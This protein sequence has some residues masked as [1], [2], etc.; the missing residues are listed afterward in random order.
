VAPR[1]A[2]ATATAPAARDGAPDGPGAGGG[3]GYVLKALEGPDQPARSF[4]VSGE[5]TVGRSSGAD[6][7]LAGDTFVSSRH[8]RIWAEAGALWLEDLGSTNGT[9]VNGQTVSARTRLAPGDR[10]Q[11]GRTIIEVAAA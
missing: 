7:P 2:R 5:I 9:V 8:A 6:I 11:I 4:P 1:R 3:G 10:V